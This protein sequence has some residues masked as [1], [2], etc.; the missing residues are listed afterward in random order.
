M[1]TSASH[2][3]EKNPVQLVDMLFEIKSKLIFQIPL[4]V[5]SEQKP[6]ETPA[7]DEEQKPAGN[8]VHS[9]S[10]RVTLVALRQH[11]RSKFVSIPSLLNVI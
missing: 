5:E 4:F 3:L 1:D 9:V 2:C 11:A 8:I 6:E 7:A 10:T